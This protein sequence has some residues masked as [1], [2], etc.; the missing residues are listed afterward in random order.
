MSNAPTKSV[1]SQYLNQV[2]P[3]ANFKSE[4]LREPGPWGL[5]EN[6]R[7]IIDLANK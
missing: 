6:N 5:I 1:K 2:T 4:V 7:R 3:W